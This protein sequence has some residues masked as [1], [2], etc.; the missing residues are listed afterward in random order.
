MATNSPLIQRRRTLWTETTPSYHLPILT[1][2]TKSQNLSLGSHRKLS[3]GSATFPI[4]RDEINN[5]RR[6]EWRVEKKGSQLDSF[7]FVFHFPVWIMKISKTHFHPSWIWIEKHF[8]GTENVKKGFSFCLWKYFRCSF[9]VR[10]SAR[11][12][13]EN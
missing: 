3:Y 11:Q 4:H 1:P 12:E 13:D 2:Y 10:F 5:N 8:T 6:I 9:G 7:L